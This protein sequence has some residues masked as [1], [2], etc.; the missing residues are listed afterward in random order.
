[1]PFDHFDLLA[2]IYA[3]WGG[4]SIPDSELLLLGLTRGD[5]LLDAGGGTGGVAE[6]VRNQV[7]WAIVADFSQKMLSHAVKKGLPA[8]RAP[9][10]FLPFCDHAFTRIVMRDVFHH[11]EDHGTAI[12]EVWRVLAPGGR[13][14]IVEPDINRVSVKVLAVIEKLMLM[15]S[16]FFQGETIA[17]FFVRSESRVTVRRETAHVL[18]MA[19]KVR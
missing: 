11:L 10:E 4:I 17:S 18:V 5:R 16:H 13:I 15:R 1:M 6:A 8:T 2:G 12:R 14:L 3:H 19:E 7:A 9:I